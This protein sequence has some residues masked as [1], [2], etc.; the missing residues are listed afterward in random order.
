LELKEN[1]LADWAEEFMEFSGKKYSQRLAKMFAIILQINLPKYKF[2]SK[3]FTNP[4]K[5][6]WEIFNR[7]VII[8]FNG[9]SAR[10]ITGI[11]QSVSAKKGFPI[12]GELS[13]TNNFPGTILYYYEVTDILSSFW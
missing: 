1:S 9:L 6:G 13:R 4:I 2:Q 11:T 7:S 3:R 12:T 5:N 10:I 8:S